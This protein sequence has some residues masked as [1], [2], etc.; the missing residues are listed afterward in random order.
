[1]SAEQSKQQAARCSQLAKDTP[2][3]KLKGILL[4]EAQAWT[5]LAEE[6]EWLERRRVERRALAKFPT[7]RALLSAHSGQPPSKRER[8]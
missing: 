6:Q 2:S 1:M 5:F 4:A 8:R 3:A 7:I